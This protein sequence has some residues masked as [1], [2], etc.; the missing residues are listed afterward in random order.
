MKKKMT[1]TSLALVACLAAVS[2]ARAQQTKDIVDTAVA[3]GSFKT[4]AKALTAADLVGTL[5]GA[6]PFTVFAPTDEA[7]AKLPAGTLDNLLKPEN[8]AMLVRVLTYHV[9]P[10]RVM[11]ADVVKINS[12]KAVSGDSLH[13]KA[14]GGNVM[15]DKARVTKT[16]IIASNGVIHVID[17]VLLPPGE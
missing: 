13:I 9:V 2:P 10:G 17:N 12:A 14:T 1:F 8:K 15:V 3:A 5:K 11:A 4:L 16:D 6:G 7:F